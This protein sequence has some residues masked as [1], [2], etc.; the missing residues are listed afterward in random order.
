MIKQDILD[1]YEI[2]D[3]YGD[4]RSK[5]EMIR[6]VETGRIGL[7]HADLYP[8][9]AYHGSEGYVINIGDFS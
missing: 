7:D 5:E 8:A 4:I 9:M 1:S 6:I 2:R 3:G